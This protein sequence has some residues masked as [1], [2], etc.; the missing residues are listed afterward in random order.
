MVPEWKIVAANG[1]K[2]PKSSRRSVARAGLVVLCV[3]EAVFS[4]W[5]DTGCKADISWLLLTVW[6]PAAKGLLCFEMVP[7][8]SI[9]YTTQLG[10]D[11]HES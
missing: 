10:L 7:I 11:H 2:V 3:Q 9:T 8:S 1:R 5:C 4:T 6:C